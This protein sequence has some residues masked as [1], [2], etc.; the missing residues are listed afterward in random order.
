MARWME[1][2]N[3]VTGKFCGNVQGGM[4]GCWKKL[5]RVAGMNCV[6][7]GSQMGEGQFGGSLSK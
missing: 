4:E 7:L 6:F 3:Q 5:S 2:R 1:N